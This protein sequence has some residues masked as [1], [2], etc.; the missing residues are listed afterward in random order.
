MRIHKRVAITYFFTLLTVIW[1]AA[2]LLLPGFIPTHDGEFSILRIKEFSTMLKNGYIFP[3][4]APDFNSSYGIPLFNFYYPF[5]YYIGSLFYASGISLVDSFKLTLATGYV[6]AHTFT[7]L[8]LYKIKGLKAAAYGSVFFSFVPYWFVEMYV[9]GSVGEVLALAWIM[10][11]FASIEYGKVRAVAL[12]TGVLIPTHNILALLF[13]PFLSLYALI[14]NKRMI[15]GVILGILIAAYFWIPA[16]AERQYV[17]GLNTADYRDHFPEIYQLLI[18]S[19]GTGFSGGITSDQI[20][21]QLGII[22]LILIIL[23]VLRRKKHD[24]LSGFFLCITLV[25]L[26]LMIPAGK[27]VWDLFTP[28]HFIQYPWRFLTFII[29]VSSFFGAIVANA[30]PRYVAPVLVAFAVILTG[31][32]T[33]PVIY[34]NRSDEYYL[35]NRNFTDGTSSMGNAFSTK[36]HS[37][38]K[39]RPVSRFSSNNNLVTGTY[40]EHPGSLL[41]NINARDNAILSVNL[42]Y[43]PGWR[44]LLDGKKIPIEPDN[45]GNIMLHVPKGSHS[46]DMKFGETPLRLVADSVTVI[47]L[48]SLTVLAILKPSHNRR[49]GRIQ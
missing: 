4:W 33:R 24:I 46:I 16:I 39:I 2:P 32:Y 41:G 40:I 45:E 23:A 38:K 18:P 48:L 43:Y 35:T 11:I 14:R 28:L 13:V 42:A 20:S 47:S 3:R 9:R 44:V 26:F 49:T 10:G 15:W 36:W 12:L 8:W 29:V 1:A 21:F 27:F 5:P 31:S 22:P 30:Y 19:W 25:S 7:F 34:D 17:I 6:V 37:W